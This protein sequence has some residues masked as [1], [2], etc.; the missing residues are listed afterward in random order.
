MCEI[1]YGTLWAAGAKW[2][3]NRAQAKEAAADMV[4]ER[5]IDE[6]TSDERFE[7]RYDAGMQLAGLLKPYQDDDVVVLGIPRGGVVTAAGVARGLWAPLDIILVKKI[8]YPADPEC[9]LGA[10]VDGQKPYYRNA[11]RG[12]G[13]DSEWLDQAEQMAYQE[14]E[15]RRAAY[16]GD[17]HRAV[18]LK[19]KTVI[20]VDDGMA[21]GLSME[22]AAWAV[23]KQQPARVIVAVPVAS[24]E[25]V[26]ELETVAD[27]VVVL[28]DPQLFMGAVSRHYDSFDQVDDAEVE[29]VLWDAD[30]EV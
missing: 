4:G 8:I 19:G 16:Y 22:A 29:R 20:L 1:Y 15:R 27:K 21:T 24:P 11:D 25:S 30:D 9:A 23:R 28:S 12:E 2:V 6:A 13:A 17:Y 14:I 7:N 18:A 5:V 3:Y 10:V 26:A